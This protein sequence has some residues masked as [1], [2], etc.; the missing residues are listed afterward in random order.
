[1]KKQNP[2]DAVAET[3]RQHLAAL[4]QLRCWTY[5]RLGEETGLSGTHVARLIR[6]ANMS[7]TTARK[8]LD[9]KSRLA[10]AGAVV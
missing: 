8:I 5:D 3:A 2:A 7:I 10:A 9:H 6:G 1:M 4:M